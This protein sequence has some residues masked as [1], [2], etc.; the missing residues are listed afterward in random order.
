MMTEMET[1]AAERI[2][3]LRYCTR[4][5]GDPDAA[6]D[7]VQAT[8]LAAW[9]REEQ[10]RDPQAR[11]SWLLSIARNTC[12]M[13]GRRQGRE[14]ARRVEP[15]HAEEDD[16]DGHL[17]DDFDLEVELER[18]ELADLL[19]RALALLPEETREVLIRRYIEDTPHAEIAARLRLSEGAVEARLH[20]GKLALK[21]VLSNDL[22]DEAISCGL[23]SQE[24]AGWQATRMWCP[25]CGMRRLE[26]QLIPDDGQI[27]L[28]CA[29]CSLPYN[30]Y[31]NAYGYRRPE[32]KTFKPGT[33]RVLDTIY[34]VFHQRAA[35]GYAPCPGCGTMLPIVHGGPYDVYIECGDCG[36][37]DRE[38]WHSLTWSL[39]QTRAF[40]QDH[41]RMRFIPQREIEVDGVPAVLT[42]FENMAG[43][44]R[45]DVV[46]L[47]DSLRVVRIS[48]SGSHSSPALRL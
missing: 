38:S 1:A 8:L 44:A 21:R 45:L 6:E 4:Y 34:E 14:R 10:L 43:T 20:R 41:P 27:N 24:D 3:L 39:P 25:G 47:R 18:E 48:R 17:A 22:S 2:M 15:G 16:L 42:G 19:D 46:R 37:S 35:D 12:A 31:L 26:G 11:P 29:G 7:L 40:W 33:M 30:N 9:R 32:I 23:L 28:R 5:T 36:L 13:W